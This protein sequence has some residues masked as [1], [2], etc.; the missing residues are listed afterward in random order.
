MSARETVTTAPHRALV[1][2][3]YGQPATD[4]GLLMEL[5]LLHTAQSSDSARTTDPD[6]SANRAGAP[7]RTGMIA[8]EISEHPKIFFGKV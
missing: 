1:G 7:T 6:S 5:Q 8:F 2:L 4:K 3:Y